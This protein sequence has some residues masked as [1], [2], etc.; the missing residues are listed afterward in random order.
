MAFNG[1]FSA[2]SL[3]VLA[4]VAVLLITPS[5]AA[6]NNHYDEMNLQSTK[7]ILG[8]QGLVYCKSGPEV[9][10]LEGSVAR[11][12]C[13][14]VDEYGMESAPITILSD[15]TDAKGYFFATLSPYEIQNHKKL[16]QCRAFLELSPLESCNVPT[17]LNN[18]ITGAVLASYRLLHDKT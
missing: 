9:I 15:A 16:T 11:I 2:T 4:L 8:I 10:P 18:G 13:E 1:F 5:S 14:T 3:L 7:S 6:G 12:T 17:D